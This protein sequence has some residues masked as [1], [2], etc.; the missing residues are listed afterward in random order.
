MKGGDAG[1]CVLCEGVRR[2]RAGPAERGRFIATEGGEKK[3]GQARLE[4]GAEELVKV[5]AAVLKEHRPHPSGGGDAVHHLPRAEV[6]AEA[7][8]AHLAR[9]VD[10]ADGAA[11]G[12][13]PAAEE[14]RGRG[15]AEVGEFHRAAEGL[16]HLGGVVARG[17]LRRGLGRGLGWERVLGGGD[18]GRGRGRRERRRWGVGGARLGARGIEEHLD[19][20]SELVGGAGDPLRAE[21]GKGGGG[22]GLGEGW[23]AAAG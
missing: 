17:E 14:V 13:G 4:S 22:A 21:G 2:G 5:G 23:S 8:E 10:G 1:A 3:H 11:L 9:A 20:L 12:G 18:G 16:D 15:K 6:E 7:R 19:E